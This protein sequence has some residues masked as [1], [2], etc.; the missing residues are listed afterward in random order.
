M[1]PRHRAVV[2]H[3]LAEH[4]G[5]AEPREPHQIAARLGV[6]G[7][8]ED[9]A[10]LRDQRKHVA[11]LHD[12]VG[13]RVGPRGDLHGARA[14]GGGDAG[15]DPFGRLDRDGEVRAVD[16]AVVGRHRRQPQPF[17]VLGGDRHADQ[18]A[19]V[20]REEVDL[21]GRDEVR[22]E[23]EVAFVLAV[24]LID[25]DDHPAGLEVGDDLRGRAQ[26]HGGGMRRR[27]PHFTPRRTIAGIVRGHAV[28]GTR[29]GAGARTRNHAA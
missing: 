3:D 1:Q 17:G 6:A 21:L 19:A 11:R 13:R 8:H 26:G 28:T 15:R 25:E 7:A 27:K 20:L 5:R 24:L 23:H 2:V 12:V 9:A 22:G 14:V 10:R 4:G 18:T 29:A 16:G